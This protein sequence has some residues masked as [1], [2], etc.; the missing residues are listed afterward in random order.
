MLQPGTEPRVSLWPTQADRL[1]LIPD[2]ID[3][4][5]RDAS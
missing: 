5:L 1:P 4:I 3:V 2:R